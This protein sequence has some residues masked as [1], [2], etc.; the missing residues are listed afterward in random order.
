MRRF[1][2][3]CVAAGI[4][5]ST[6]VVVS[7]AQASPWS[8]VRYDNTGYCQIWNDGMTFKPLKWPS[9]Y[10]MVGKPVPTLSAAISVR[11]D[12]IKKGKCR[13]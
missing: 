6:F 12:L 13:G 4:A 8:L 10:K 2:A 5:L 9:D 3:L 1:T 7:P 11:D